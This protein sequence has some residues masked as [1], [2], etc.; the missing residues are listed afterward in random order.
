MTEITIYECEF[1]GKQFA[2]SWECRE[3]EREEQQNKCANH[4][5]FR[6]AEGE[7][8]QPLS[9]GDPRYITI[10]DE[11]GYELVQFFFKEDGYLTP[12]DDTGI[13]TGNFYYGNGC[14]H[15]LEEEFDSL[16]CI[17]KKMEV[18]LK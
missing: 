1:C 2:N 17:A 16:K 12:G 7:I 9:M 10:L 15:C 4:V 18:E 3:H 6:D 8:F 13:Q 5:I 14:W 11:I